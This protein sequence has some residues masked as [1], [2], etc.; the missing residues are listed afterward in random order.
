MFLI[1]NIF[2]SIPVTYENQEEMECKTERSVLVSWE[3]KAFELRAAAEE[4]NRKICRVEES[5][6]TERMVVV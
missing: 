2:S 3:R 4:L 6:S 1:G 5:Y